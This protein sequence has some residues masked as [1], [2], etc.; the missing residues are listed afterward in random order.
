[1]Y[2]KQAWRLVRLAGV[3]LALSW[4]HASPVAGADHYVNP[5]GVCGGTPC[6]MTIQAAIDA[7]A[8]LDTVIVEAGTYAENVVLAKQLDMR[9]AQYGVDAR[10]RVTG[11][12]NPLVESII[13]PASGTG[14]LLKSGSAG[15]SLDGFSFLGG[16]KGV[17]SDTG[18]INNVLIQNNHFASFTGNAIFLND[19]GTDVTINQN[20]IDS[21]AKVGAG[22]IV[23]LDTDSFLG[24]HFTDNSIVSTAAMPPGTGF[25]VDGNRNVKPSLTPRSPLFDGN[26]ITNQ[27][28]GM[29]LGTRALEGGSIIHN[30]F[31]GNSFDGLQGGMKDTLISENEFT[32]N[33]RWGLSLTSFG[34]TAADRGAQNSTVE[35]NVFTGNG[36]VQATG[37]AIVFSS[38]Q[39]AGTISTNVFRFNS[40]SGNNV[41]ASYTGPAA[42]ETIDAEKNWWGS[43]SGPLHSVRNTAGTGDSVID[44]D[45]AGIVDFD[46]W[47]CSGTDL[48][49]DIGFQP[50][51]AA[52]CVGLS[53]TKVVDWIG[54]T[55]DAG[56]TFEICITGPSYPSG[57]CQTV[58]FDGGLLTW[59]VEPG[60]YTVTET[61][62]GSA[63]TVNIEGS[64]VTV[65]SGGGGEATV[66]NTY[67]RGTLRVTKTVDWGGTKASTAQ[68]FEICAT[69]PS[70][71]SGACETLGRFGGVIVWSGL[72]PGSYAVTE[73]SPGSSWVVTIAGSPADVPAGGTANATVTNAIARP[74][75]R[76]H[77]NGPTIAVAGGPVTYEYQVTNPGNAPLSNVA[78]SDDRCPS[79]AYV[80]GDVANT[81]L[82]DVGETWL[83]SC[84]YTPAFT[85]SKTL[86]NKAKATAKF[87]TKTV[88]ATDSFTL[89]PFTLKKRVY[90]KK[91]SKKID[92]H[93]DTTVFTVQIFEGST[94]VQTLTVA[95]N[96]PLKVWLGP[97]SFTFKEVA[98]PSGYSPDG[99]VKVSTKKKA[100]GGTLSNRKNL[101]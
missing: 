41:G 86:T 33:G 94:L 4:V 64:P 20:S 101:S 26:V 57:D 35:Y 51:T 47:L 39:A 15:S 17:E 74:K 2:T 3:S 78:V 95:Q 99:D 55:P 91:G 32:G 22:G 52:V 72:V 42:L 6:Y 83:F 49:T 25:F 9:G 1:V 56:Q 40:V 29:N 48:S 28:T 66:T 68:T 45:P 67:R 23:H 18:P 30:T 37:G 54:A 87:G 76:I 8:A 73:T 97:G 21:T 82:L 90:I 5:S 77:K 98:V 63:W 27:L 10:G 24:F 34:N 14:L 89:S 31:S 59:N 7:A 93:S 19:S 81:G 61:D 53:V 16:A 84:T 60:E 85:P 46:P 58:D 71:P 100:S 79:P 12:P 13:A 65:T 92:V 80:S 44:A 36:F 75:I 96:A 11:A 38:T 70:F 43:P 62:P 88:S 50:D 69:G